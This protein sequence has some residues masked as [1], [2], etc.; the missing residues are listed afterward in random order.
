[1]IQD[2]EIMA[3]IYIPFFEG[4]QTVGVWTRKRLWYL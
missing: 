3:D 1:M 4:K 2:G